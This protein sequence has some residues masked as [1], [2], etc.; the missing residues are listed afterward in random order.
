MGAPEL[1]TDAAYLL[2]PTAGNY[3]RRDMLIEDENDVPYVLTGATVLYLSIKKKASDEDVDAIFN[4]DLTLY[5]Q[6]DLGVGKIR[7]I[8]VDGDLTDDMVGRYK[9]DIKIAAPGI[10]SPVNLPKPMAEITIS[11]RSRRGS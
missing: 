6:P 1:D 9:W 8:F 4:K 11:G 10:D 3:Y 7:I 2:D 5:A